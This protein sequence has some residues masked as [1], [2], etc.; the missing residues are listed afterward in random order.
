LMFMTYQNEHW[1]RYL[2]VPWEGLSEA[3][4]RIFNPK[5]VDAQMNGVQ[6]VLF[7]VIGLG[8]TIIGWRSMRNSY[9]VWMVANW[10]IFVSTS[11]VLSVPRYTLTLFPLFISMALVARRNWSLKVLFVCWSGLYLALFILRFVSGLWAF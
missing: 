1:H 4:K 3:W 5:V 2:R 9:R 6:E 10:L 11:F 8:A 7:V